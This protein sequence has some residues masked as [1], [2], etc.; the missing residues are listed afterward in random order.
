MSGFTNATQANNTFT[1]TR[2]SAMIAQNKRKELDNLKIQVDA[3]K[4]EN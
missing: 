2:T 4:S 3:L 1:A